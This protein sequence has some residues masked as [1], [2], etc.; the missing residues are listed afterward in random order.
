[1][2]IPIPQAGCL[3]SFHVDCFVSCSWSKSSGFH[4]TVALAALSRIRSKR[5]I[6][7][8]HASSLRRTLCSNKI[9]PILFRTSGAQWCDDSNRR[10]YRF[11]WKCSKMSVLLRALLPVSNSSPGADL[12]L[13]AS[14][15]VC[16]SLWISW[17]VAGSVMVC[18]KLSPGSALRHFQYS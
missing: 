5:E 11:V 15:A 18:P 12:Q 14:A 8:R 6:S 17:T 2:W 16:P 1:M 3:G 9:N 7:S 10:S 13:A 4:K